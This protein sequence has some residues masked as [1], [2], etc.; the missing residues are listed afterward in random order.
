ME[1]MTFTVREGGQ[2]I[3]DPTT[4]ERIKVLPEDA[5]TREANEEAECSQE[6]Q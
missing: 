5:A 2:Y 1:G 4:K 3:V 6:K